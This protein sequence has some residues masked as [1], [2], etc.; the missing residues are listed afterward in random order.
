MQGLVGHLALA[1]T[2]VS[3]IFVLMSVTHFPFPLRNL[4]RGRGRFACTE[5]FR[6]RFGLRLRFGLRFRLR[7]VTDPRWHLVIE[8]LDNCLLWKLLAA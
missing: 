2:P 3:F 5:S 4:L 1:Y 7:T 8:T 6:A